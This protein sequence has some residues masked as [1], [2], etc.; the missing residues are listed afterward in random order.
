[1]SQVEEIEVAIQSLSPGELV[2]F[3]RWFAEFDAE[4]WDEQIAADSKSGK[5]NHLID[6]ALEE[7]RSGRVIEL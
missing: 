5:L 4:I 6:E 2:E 1:M 3:R 7:Y